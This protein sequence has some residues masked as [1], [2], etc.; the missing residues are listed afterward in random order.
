MRIGRKTG[1]LLFAM[2]V[3]TSL[4]AAEPSQLTKIRSIEGITEYRLDNGLQVLFFPDESKPK[5]TTT[6][7]A[8]FRYT[9]DAEK[10]ACA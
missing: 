7:G 2:F 5:I 3:S 9:A 1:L 10:S 4:M 6:E 8:A